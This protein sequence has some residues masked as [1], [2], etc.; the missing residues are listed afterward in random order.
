MPLK[1]VVGWAKNKLCAFRRW[2]VRLA[3]EVEKRLLDINTRTRRAAGSSEKAGLENWKLD[4]CGSRTKYGSM[5][6]VLHV[7]TWHSRCPFGAVAATGQ[8][9]AVKDSTVAVL[10]TIGT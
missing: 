9:G 5:H 10:A 8:L 3:R 7:S 4:L 1:S 6:K 2:R